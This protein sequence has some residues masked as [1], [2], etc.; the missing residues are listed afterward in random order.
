MASKGDSYF[1]LQKNCATLATSD[2]GVVAVRRP[3]RPRAVDLRYL[4]LVR[5][6]VGVLVVDGVFANVADDEKRAADAHGARET[7]LV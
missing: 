1:T 4:R 7:T 6:Q 5:G 2:A 3:D